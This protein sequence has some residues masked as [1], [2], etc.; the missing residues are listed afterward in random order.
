MRESLSDPPHH[1]LRAHTRGSCFARRSLFAVLSA[2]CNRDTTVIVRD[3]PQAALMHSI[4]LAPLLDEVRMRNR[5]DSDL[6]E[7]LPSQ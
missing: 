3:A 4:N 2:K 1:A 5:V 6:P 7:H